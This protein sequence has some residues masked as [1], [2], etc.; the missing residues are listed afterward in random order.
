MH[1][2]LPAKDD[3]IG[4]AGPVTRLAPS[5]TGALH[6]GNARTFLINWALAKRHSWEV[7]AR[8]EDLDTPRVKPGALEQT[9]ETLAWLGL[10]WTGVVL[11]Q[12]DDLTPYEDA[13]CK[14]ARL[15]LVYP[16]ELT[17][18][19]IEAAAS[20][21]QDGVAREA[22]FDPSLRPTDRPST[23]ED[24]GTNWRFVVEPGVVDFL[25]L[26]AGPQR[27][28][29][30]QGVGDFVVWTKRAQPSYQ[31][32][33]TVD[34]HRQ[35]VT[36]IV[37]GNDLIDS[38]GRQALLR[39]A[40]GIRPEPVHAHLPLV[41]GEDGR[42]LAKRHGDTRLDTY[43]ARGVPPERVI[44]L[45]ASWSGVGPTRVEMN[46]HDFAR[47]FSLDTM[48]RNDVT[49]TPEDEQWLFKSSTPSDS[50]A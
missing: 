5:P 29:V 19:E 25:D 32:A 30:D 6:L 28:D 21:P 9:L 31:L 43:R 1:A 22:R 44:G 42:R 3:E 23:F 10:D 27:V 38:T 16:C 4:P 48:P 13:M 46:A 20:A 35:G 40:L 33:V 36:H 17:R 47:A 15:G 49:F 45:L 24:T 37:R 41:R 11:V 34:D 2:S 14:L 26:A 7:V 8:I 39:K 50:P 18:S 12:S